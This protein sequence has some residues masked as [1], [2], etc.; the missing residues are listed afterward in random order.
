MY[1]IFTFVFHPVSYKAILNRLIFT[2]V[3]LWNLLL[4]QNALNSPLFVS[5]H[6]RSIRRSKTNWRRNGKRHREKLKRRSV[7][8]MRRYK[9][10]GRRLF[11]DFFVFKFTRLW[12]KKKKSHTK[13]IN[14][15]SSQVWI[16]R[17]VISLKHYHRRWGK[18]FE[19]LDKYPQNLCIGRGVWLLCKSGES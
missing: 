1:L 16:L 4:I 12:T 10:E 6:R 15:K 17:R 13:L 7:D 9:A 11:I 3:V 19:Y 5:T 8:T 18:L 2:M 14:K